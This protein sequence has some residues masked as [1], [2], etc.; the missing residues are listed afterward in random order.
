[1]FIH[2][3]SKFSDH[4]YDYYLELFMGDYLSP[5]HL[6]LLMFYLVPSFGTYSSLVSFCLI[7]C[8]YFCVFGR[9]V[10]FPDLGEVAFYKV[11]PMHPS[12][13][14]PSRHQIYMLLGCPLYGLHGSFFLWQADYCGWSGRLSW[15]PVWLPGPVLCEGC[16]LV[17][18]GHEAAGCSTLGGGSQVPGQV[19]AHWW[20]ESRCR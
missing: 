9:L 8:F 6:V 17:G 18:S 3:S 20:V 5:L 14:L 10:M 16:W 11:H 12:S 4:L 1:M 7:L 2:S 19:L 13:S 15:P